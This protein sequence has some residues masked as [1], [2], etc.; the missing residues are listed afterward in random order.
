MDRSDMRPEE[1]GSAPPLPGTGKK[2][3]FNW[4]RLAVILLIAAVLA[5][6]SRPVVIKNPC[7]QE[8]EPGQG[9]IIG[10]VDTERY[11]SI[12][13]A[14][15]IGATKEG[16]AVFKDP[17]AAFRKLKRLYAKDIR[18][19]GWKNHLPPLNHLTH[20][21]YG[22]FGWQTEGAAEGCWFVSSFMDIY[23]NSFEDLSWASYVSPTDLT[24]A[25]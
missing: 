7:V 15:A 3:S 14:F 6:L 20:G 16:V 5:G 2:L 12:S 13:P 11:E 9:N 23:E 24:P 19:I 1:R 10:A 8:Y 17:R 22:V 4:G 21:L 18:Y 25:E